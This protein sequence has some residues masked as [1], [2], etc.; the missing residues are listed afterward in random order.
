MIE[1]S[2]KEI[3]LDRVLELFFRAIK[4]E[5]IS[6][7][8][9]AQEYNVST[10]TISRDINTLKI[11]L[12]EHNEQLGYSELVYSSTNHCY[13]LK[14]DALFTNKELLAITK[15]L[16]A[17]RAFKK[18]E[19]DTIIKKLKNNTSTS[20]RAKLELLISKD[21]SH[22]DEI[23]NNC[24]SIISNIWRLTEC[25]ENKNIITIS[26]QKMNLQFVEKKIKPLSIIFSEYYFYLIASLCSNI[27]TKDELRYFR[28]DKISNITIHRETYSFID[29]QN[30]NEALLKKKSH[31]M[32]PGSPQKIRFEFFGPSVQAI[33]D[34]IP[35]S[36]IIEKKK[37]SY[38][39]E[40]DVIG[41]GIKMVLL[42]QGAW[43][44]VLA[45][46]N[47]VQEMKEE[48]SKLQLLY[49]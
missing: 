41:P 24:P 1:E 34:R 11:F 20:D 17:S 25:I 4:G 22:Y 43:V 44:K 37:H 8:R 7:K 2:H 29:T 35:T 5:S 48:L 45:P 40:A 21:L 38:I 16:I 31:Y 18:E 19:I 47:L 10:R 14:I 26:Y 28:I 12:A 3:Q 6:A 13:K 27:D 42:S 32:W 33:L 49:K 36:K 39:L 9:L 46:N 23:K 15:V 30:V